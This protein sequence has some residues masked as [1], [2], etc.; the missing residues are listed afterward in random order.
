[1][2]DT[3]QIRYTF[4]HGDDTI[5]HEIN[6]DAQTLEHRFEQ[7][8]PVPAW[9]ALEF[10]QCRGCPLSSAQSPH[11]PL[12]LSLHE[13]VA[14]CRR[15]ISYTEIEAHVELPDRK[16]Y[17]QTTAQKAIMSLLGLYMATSAC[18]NM[19]PLRPMARFHTPF[20]S[21]E[22]TIFRSAS[23]YLLAQ[24]FRRHRGQEADMD[25]AGLGEAYDKIHRVNVGM[26]RRLRHISE[27]DANLNALVLLDLHAQ[28][29]PTA[30]DE[31]L[32][33]IE[34]LFAPFLCEEA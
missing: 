25:L 16:I 10:E 12:A 15:L 21:R 23:A 28:E 14:M 31:R 30:I 3:I 34:Y 24:Y 7:P 26:A 32:R 4:H 1:M 33:E 11:C 2:R 18:P 19:R 17:K 8:D 13:L 6:L 20:A 29:M 5:V 22:E 27:G 9:A